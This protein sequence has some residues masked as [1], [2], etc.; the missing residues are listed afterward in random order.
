MT[1]PTIDQL[2]AYYSALSHL[3]REH[4]PA[5]VTDTAAR[6]QCDA[7]AYAMTL[8]DRQIVSV[9]RDG[10]RERAEATVPCPDCHGA[11]EVCGG[12]C[13]YCE[14]DRMVPRACV[15]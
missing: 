4:A 2:R 7:L 1:T 3:L 6:V 12:M 15:D 13:A 11:G 10:A 8:I 5:T 14:G 9:R